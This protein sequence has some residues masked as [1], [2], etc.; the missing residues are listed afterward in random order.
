MPYVRKRGVGDTTQQPMTAAQAAAWYN[1]LPWY[2]KPFASITGTIQSGYCFVNSSDPICATNLYTD[3]VAAA[4]APGLPTGY[5]PATGTVAPLNT[6]GQTDIAGSYSSA[7]SDALPAVTPDAAS[8]LEAIA[9]GDFSCIPGWAW[10]LLA[11]LGV[12]FFAI[13]IAPLMGRRH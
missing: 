12:G 1:A 2:V 9:A 11:V 6:T 5:I 10:G 3:Q 7:I 4:T 13:E 8:C